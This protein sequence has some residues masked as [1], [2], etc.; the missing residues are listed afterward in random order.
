M[1][2]WRL[3]LHELLFLRFNNDFN[4]N[5]Q[6]FALKAFFVIIFTYLNTF[7]KMVKSW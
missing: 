4:F 3:T 7:K 1:V 5:K 2:L 6:A